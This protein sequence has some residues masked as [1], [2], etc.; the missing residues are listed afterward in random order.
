[1]WR[2]F[3]DA[4]R[5][6]VVGVSSSVVDF[7]FY[8]G[9]TRAAHLP[10]LVANVLA[11]LVGHLVSYLGNRWW[12][13]RSHGSVGKEYVRFWVTNLIGLAVSQT[14]LWVGLTLGIHDL[15]AK[16]GAIALSGLSNFLLNRHWTFRTKVSS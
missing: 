8:F 16:V 15:V 11:Y 13:F 6:G 7:L 14:V 12:T 3:T 1:M 10:E 9:L 5:Y 4:M 2:L